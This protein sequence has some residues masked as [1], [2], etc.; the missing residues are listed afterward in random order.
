M[1][2]FIIV[3]GIFLA[4]NLLAGAAPRSPELTNNIIFLESADDAGKLPTAKIM[5]SMSQVAR[6]MN[7]D[8]RELPP[9][10]IF[11]VSPKKAARLGVKHNALRINR[12]D[13]R[14]PY[15]E[16]WLVDDHKAVDYTVAF[17]QILERHFRS[18]S[19]TPTE[20]AWLGESFA[21]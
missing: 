17:E 13:V 2:R 3:A 4:A 16:L 21:I 20:S 12:G 1:F 9:I 10:L 19:L 15:F 5:R 8:Q 11:H 18:H 14:D 6:E 7:L